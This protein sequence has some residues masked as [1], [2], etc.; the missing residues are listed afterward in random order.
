MFSSL[1]R[2]PYAFRALAGYYRS[3]TGQGAYHHMHSWDIHA[4]KQTNF[5]STR[6]LAM[7]RGYIRVNALNDFYDG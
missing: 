5:V 6:V 1:P 4:L 2:I 3:S 7:K